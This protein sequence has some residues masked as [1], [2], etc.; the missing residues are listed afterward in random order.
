[1]KTY[2]LIPG[3]ALVLLG[4]GCALSRSQ[5]NQVLQEVSQREAVVPP[6]REEPKPVE[7]KLAVM[8]APEVTEAAPVAPRAVT[9][10]ASDFSFDP[11]SITA[12][13]GEEMTITF[14]SVT[15]HHVF[16]I[17]ELSISKEMSPGG[18]VTFIAPTTPG[19]YTYYC[20]VGPH[21]TLGM[22]GTLIVE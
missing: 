2:W 7:A 5:S 8:A 6:V 19:R 10:N 13:A 9:V 18:S 1:M 3:F 12:K 4:A 22:T 14:G 21:R 11:K 20:S 16:T 17:D 15:G